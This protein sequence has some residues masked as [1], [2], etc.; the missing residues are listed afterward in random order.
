MLFIQYRLQREIIT[1]AAASTNAADQATSSI[2]RDAHAFQFARI[3]DAHMAKPSIL[4][5]ATA[6]AS[7]LLSAQQLRYSALNH[8]N[9]N[10]M[11]TSIK[12]VP[13]DTSLTTL[14][15]DVF[16]YQLSHRPQNHQHALEVLKKSATG[17]KSSTLKRAN[18]NA[19]LI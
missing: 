2:S 17:F 3:V 14:H 10:V 9:A 5:F 12:T 11:K 19:L 18:V 13:R 7:K 1:M 15:V 6:N 8:A 16:R 4:I